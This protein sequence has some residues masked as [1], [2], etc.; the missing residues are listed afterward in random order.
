M[1]AAITQR[2]IGIRST[3]VYVKAQHTDITKTWDRFG[4]WRPCKETQRQK[5]LLLNNHFK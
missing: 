3:F 1:Q 4:S 5:R 2:S